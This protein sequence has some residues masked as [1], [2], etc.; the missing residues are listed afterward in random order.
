MPA[1]LS[2]SSFLRHVV[3]E[4]FETAKFSKQWA[5]RLKLVVDELFMNA[6]KYGSTENTSFIHVTFEY[7]DSGVWF[8][9]EDDGTGPED[10][11]VEALQQ[12]IQQNQANTDLAKTSGRGLA[13]ITSLWTDGMEVEKSSRGGI[14]V[15][16]S[17]QLSAAEDPPP[18]PPVSPEIAAAMAA[19]SA[20]ANPVEGPID[21]QIDGQ[22][23][24]AR[25]AVPQP[26]S[27]SVVE[28]KLS[29]E[30][31]Q[32]NIEEK[33][34]PV[35]QQLETIPDGAIL[36]LDF[37][38]LTYINSTFIGNLAAWHT[39]MERKGG[40]V[41]LKNVNDSIRE[42]LELVGLL[43]VLQCPVASQVGKPTLQNIS[44]I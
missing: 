11:S 5:S 39:H 31:D 13:M 14:L 7:D 42:I 33:T 26:A 40:H 20:N 27:Q 21:E 30:I 16:F 17:K 25:S 6:V 8:A 43:K 3:S 15:R 35:T 19:A 29:G 22:V 36:S 28:I 12:K 34:A 41:C 23:P 10:A 38:D 24:L 44:K 9:I 37:S 32:S 4:L 18:A 2:H 1:S